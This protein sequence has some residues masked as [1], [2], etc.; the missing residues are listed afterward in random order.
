[1]ET[2]VNL[3]QHRLLGPFIFYPLYTWKLV[4]L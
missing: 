2:E 1:M 3:L 4:V